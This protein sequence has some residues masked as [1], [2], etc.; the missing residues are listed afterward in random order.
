MIVYQHTQ[1]TNLWVFLVL[2]V[3]LL[4]FISVAA[5]SVGIA[6]LWVPIAAASLVAIRAF[7]RLTVEV[8]DE[9]LSAHFGGSWPRRRI[10]LVEITA[11]E[12]VRNSWWRGFGI[13]KI[14][15]GW[16]WNVWGLDGVELRL[17]SGKRFRVGTDEPDALE[18][19]LAV[20]IGLR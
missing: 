8:T 15:K 10:K 18:A 4:V 2:A 19:V 14:A 3:D 7:S 6:L 11:V 17:V 13:R 9:E 1:S 16:M 20:R 12:R 5:A